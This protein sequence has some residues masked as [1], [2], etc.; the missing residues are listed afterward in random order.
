MK[1]LST[2][3]STPSA[4]QFH[5]NKI[6]ILWTHSLTTHSTGRAISKPLIEN[7]DGFGGLCAPVNSGVRRLV[8]VYVS[9]LGLQL[10]VEKNI[11]VVRSVLRR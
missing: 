11:N 2:T 9:N 10:W 4:M 1:K 6:S 7:S 8:V 5:N 3:E